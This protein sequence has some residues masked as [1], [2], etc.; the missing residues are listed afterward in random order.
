MKM[1]EAKKVVPLNT[2][3]DIQRDIETEKNRHWKISL[4]FT[5]E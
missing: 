3:T 5:V 1:I 4:R 2:M